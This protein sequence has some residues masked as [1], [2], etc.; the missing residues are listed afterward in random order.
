M[1]LPCSSL[2]QDTTE[3]TANVERIHAAICSCRGHDYLL[4]R[5]LKLQ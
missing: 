1:Q 3:T 2:H 5:L 4:V